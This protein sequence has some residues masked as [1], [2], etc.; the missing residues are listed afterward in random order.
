MTRGRTGR[1]A[2]KMRRSASTDTDWSLEVMT[3]RVAAA[4]SLA[5]GFTGVAVFG[6]VVAA[7]GEWVEGRQLETVAGWAIPGLTLAVLGTL[8]SMRALFVGKGRRIALALSLLVVVSLVLLIV[9]NPSI[10]PPV[11]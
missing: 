2:V 6:S 1:S 11:P 9:L 7:I 8:A 5:V 10:S 3:W 4:A